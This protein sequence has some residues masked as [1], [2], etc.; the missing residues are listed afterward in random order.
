MDE[1][2]YTQFYAN[3]KAYD[4]GHIMGATFHVGSYARALELATE[5]LGQDGISVVTVACRG[6]STVKLEAV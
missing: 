3:Q 2:I 5:D 4:K 6:Y 1:N